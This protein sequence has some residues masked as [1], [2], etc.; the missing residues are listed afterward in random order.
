MNIP[1]ID[2]KTFKAWL[3][4]GRELVLLDVREPNELEVSV[5]PGVINIPL[6]SVEDRLD[7]L[8][9]SKETVVIC[10]SGMRSGTVTELLRARGFKST[11]NL[12]GGMNA[13]AAQV[14]PTL[15]TY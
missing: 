14:D 3:D 10:R 7:E 13:Y 12:A 2:V 8:D 9:P 1:E 11:Y 4:S 6:K 5:L 15:K